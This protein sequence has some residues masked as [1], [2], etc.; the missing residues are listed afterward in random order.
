LE[1]AWKKARPGIEFAVNFLKSNAHI[2]DLQLLSSPLLLVPIAVY[3]DIK[4]QELTPGEEKD[5]LR[6]FYIAHMRGHYS[7][8][9]TESVLDGDL[10]ALFKSADLTE[11][12]RVLQQRVKQFDVSSADLESR[13]TQNPLFTM[14]YVV[15][16]QRGAKDWLSGLKLSERHVGKSHKLEHHH[17][18][19][20]SIL[21]DAQYDR[22]LI[23]EIANMAFISGKA[24]RQILNKPPSQYLPNEVIP[25]RGTEALQSQLIPLDE[26][27][28]K[29]ENY[30][31]FVEYRRR[32]IAEEINSFIHALG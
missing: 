13:G 21:R 17:I 12:L 11:L 32:A 26:E 27:L 8:G 14:L 22:K 31:K 30:T 16:R 15:L 10:S 2:D 19:P 7:L 6:W 4:N 18:F 24:N 23:N 25:K 9:S 3:S 5:L 28:W 29:I 20:K 1:S